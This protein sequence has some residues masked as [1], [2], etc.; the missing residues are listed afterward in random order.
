[1]ANSW[2]S[3]SNLPSASPAFQPDT[4]VL[5]SDGTVMVHN[6]L[7]TDSSNNTTAGWEWYRLKAD[8]NGDYDSGTWSGPF[9]MTTARQFFASAVLK[10]GRLFVLGGEY[11]SAGGDTT[12]GEI[13][14]PQTNSWSAMTT[15]FSWINGD[16]AAAVLP[17][18][19]IIFGALANSR[20]AIWDPVSDDWREAGLG[21]GA[22]ASTSKVGTT[23]E[24]GWTL[25]PEGTVLTI[26]ISGT[27]AA[28]KY[29]PAQDLWISAGAPGQSL[30][31][32]SLK[33]TTVS[34]KPDIN[35]SEI[36]PAL[37]LPDGRLFSVGATGHTALYTQGA[38]P[39]QAGSWANG[40]DLPA[41]S[42]SAKFNS[43]NGNLQ[44]AIDAPAALL[45]GGKVLLVAGNTVREVDSNNNASFWSNPSNVYVYDPIAN[46][47]PT[48]LSP[49]PPS[50]GND[51][52]TARFL[53][54]PN[55]RVL[56]SGEQGALA[57]LKLDSSLNN[58]DASW[59]PTITD[60][61][62]N[63]VTGHTYVL[64]GTLFN[65]VSGGV[66]YGD[67]AQ[68]ATNFPIVRLTNTSTNKVTYLRSTNFSTQGIAT[69]ATP[70][71]TEVNVPQGLDEGSYHLQVIANA[72]ASDSVSVHVAKQDLFIQLDRSTYSQGEI[73][74]IIGAT[75]A[76]A[77]I[78]PAVFVIVE[79]FKPSELGLNSGNLA[80]PP[81]KPT[82]P[83]PKSGVHFE[84][85]GPVVPE[86]PGLP[87]SPQRFTFPFRAKFDNGDGV[88]N[89]IIGSSETDTITAT[90][91][92]GGGSV[93][94]S[95]NV[96]LTKN[97]NPFILHGDTA[98]GYP[99]YLSVDIKTFQVKAGSH[100]FNT[101]VPN[102]GSARSDATG[103]IQTIIAA[104]NADRA[105]A[106]S[107]FDAL[108]LDE[109]PTT[110]TLA[111]TATDGTPVFNFALARIRYRDTIAANNVRAFFRMW[112]AQQ[113]NA[114]YGAP[115]TLYRSAPSHGQV[116]PLLGVQGDEIMTIPF[117]ATPRVHAESSA[118]MKDQTDTPNVQP[119]ISPSLLGGEVD[120]Y[121]G[122]WLDINQPG[123]K[124]FP[125]RM[126]GGTPA[127]LPDGPFTGMGQLLSIQELVRSEHQCLLVEV[128]F[129]LDPIPGNADPSNNDK[130]AQRN[131]TFGPA[132]NPGLE[133]SR[134]VPQIFEVRP[135]P[136]LLR[137]DLK[138]DELMIDW[139]KVPTGS[140]AQIYLP[141]TQADEIL[142]LADRFYT[143]HRLSKVDAS[144][145][146]CP[147]GGF[148]FVPIPRRAGP[149]FAG[150]LTVS[151]PEGIH[152][153]QVFDVTIRQVTSSL[154]RV[155]TQQQQINVAA[156]ATK[157]R[158]KAAAAG[159][160]QAV[161]VKGGPSEFFWRRTLG[162]F[163]LRVPV[164]T[165][166][167]LLP[168][169]MRRLSILRYIGK[170]IPHD[171]RW[172]KVFLRLL[173]QLAHRVGDMGGDPGKA[174][175]DP[176]G[177]WDGSIG[178]KGDHGRGEGEGG[179]GGRGEERFG[180]IGKVNGIRYDR[181]GDFE[182]FLLDTED[183]ERRFDAREP[184]I[185]DV[186]RRAWEERSL[187]AVFAERHAPHRAEEIVVVGPPS[188]RHSF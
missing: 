118:S 132:P 49:Q 88:F 186:V 157:G 92:A 162:C 111:Q 63:M 29:D 52:W 145:L 149:N 150:L 95:A 72:I 7:E 70:V 112:P 40:P 131:L 138:P 57:M 165:K 164:S 127:N 59:K 166:Q 68:M 155:P 34:A 30:A 171:S 137:A 143:T 181:F 188:Q 94:G 78:D 2:T 42:S 47:T 13:F 101:A 31:L 79:G 82:I 26:D 108:P 75:G 3:F 73:Q 18:G 87:N 37:V 46:T 124:L 15:P 177:D 6:T 167:H 156:A 67:D 64:T 32:I 178:G 141:A 14:D 121:F 175:P 148:T 39:S 99:W 180:V 115:T 69:G 119:T 159:G 125:V 168:G 27:P 174:I 9:N 62:A 184:R 113:T 76:P 58:P 86:D 133:A 130:L 24:E 65:G 41:D 169:E 4:M 60:F 83:D 22:I 185:E 17:D 61:P 48:L 103:F 134:R 21:F 53:L 50:N 20:T 129:D 170:S 96:V 8:D 80:N 85:S 120:T 117:F 104:F 51:T 36:G 154:G 136:L 109:D 173:E 183:G 35:I 123:E 45:P 38:S 151:L 89:S 172:Y 11:S 161:S 84:F 106:A 105:S 71:T 74:S 144:T 66:A 126:V 152:K 54:L 81:H 25:L 91:N 122:A 146:E 153:G 139:G 100:R 176:N 107:L 23:D 90:L 110:I 160:S 19:R 116:I 128:S 163:H 102:T 33:D 12:L 10:D 142:A 5:L 77:V 179:E 114:V 158:G 147:T 1:M 93:Q 182:G 187:L 56:F 97:P 43:V 55:A 135:T 44:T 28:E 140:K 98:H 16:A